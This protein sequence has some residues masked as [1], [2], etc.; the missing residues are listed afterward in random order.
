MVSRVAGGEG[1]SCSVEC[2]VSVRQNG[3]S[4]GD[5]PHSN[6]Q[7]LTVLYVCL[8]T[9]D[10]VNFIV[11][12]FFWNHNKKKIILRTAPYQSFLLIVDEP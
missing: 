10:R 3:G 4:S 2:R 8:E 6:R 12:L 1:G 7:E 9:V 11:C 5:L